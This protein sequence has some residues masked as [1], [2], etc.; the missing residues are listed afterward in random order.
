[1]VTVLAGLTG[2][3]LTLNASGRPG[4]L[5]PA[6]GGHAAETVSGSSL[7]PLEAGRFWVY[8]TEGPQT[9]RR[10]IRSLAR[11]DGGT[12]VALYQDS[13]VAYCEGDNIIE[14]TRSGGVT[15]LPLRA[16]RL[17]HTVTY[18]SQGV[19]V[20]KTVTT[21]DTSAVVEGR[22]YDHCTA[23]TTSFGLETAAQRSP[24]LS[25]VS[26]YAPG[27]GLVKCDG[28]AGMANAGLQLALRDHGLVERSAVA[29][30]QQGAQP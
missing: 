21:V 5:Q 12:V 24:S 3:A 22:R 29:D 1:V 2:A 7:Y 17:G 13:T 30:D 25:Y 9:V 28:V 6:I 10:E 8:A 16:G 19:R 23:V 18:Q 20:R 4:G 14:V 26:Y 27:I 15:V 11:T